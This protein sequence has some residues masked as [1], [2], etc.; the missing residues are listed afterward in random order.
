VRS[1]KVALSLSLL[2]AFTGASFEAARAE[3][4]VQFTGKISFASGVNDP[5]RTYVLVLGDKGLSIS[6]QV[7]SDGTYQ[8]IFPARKNVKIVLNY[9]GLLA[10]ETSIE[11]RTSQDVEI[12]GWQTEVSAL[13]DRSLDFIFPKPFKLNVRVVDAQNNLI[14]DSLIRPKSFD[15]KL[16]NVV[17]STGNIW[18][19]NQNWSDDSGGG[20]I[21]KNG[22]FEVWN[23]PLSDFGGIEVHVRGTT[24]L[25]S[26]SVAFPLKDATSIK[27]C[28]PINFGASRTL[29]ADCLA[30]DSDQRAI[31]DKAAAEAFDATNKAIDELT[32]KMNDLKF[33]YCKKASAVKKIKIQS[34]CPRGYKVVKKPNA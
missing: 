28:L 16:V 29:P 1:K 27:Y 17:N 3:T 30:A 11:K 9:R 21:S 14:P 19:G 10:D 4:Y 2:L 22:E 7:R 12:S 32:Q 13:Q 23:Y 34:T 26:R 24:N 5:G 6:T 25:V 8:L 33:K 20:L 18:T 31:G 15:S